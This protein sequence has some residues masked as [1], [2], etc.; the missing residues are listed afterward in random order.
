MSLLYASPLG[1]RTIQT[2]GHYFHP[3]TSLMYKLGLAA[4]SYELVSSIPSVLAYFGP[5]L[6]ASFAEIEK[7]E[8]KL[9]ALL[10][11]FLNMHSQVTIIGDKSADTKRRVSTISFVVEGWGSNAFVDKVYELT[12]GKMGIRWG[13]FY[14]ERLLGEFLGLNLP[15]G[16]VRV[17]F[18][19]YN[20]GMSSSLLFPRL[21]AGG[22]NR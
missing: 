6:S 8:G 4:S 9:Q 17:S 21:E 13:G 15:D 14:S 20:T 16:V 22:C 10:L 11:G 1:L 12:D 19:H 3:T 18:V 7:H 5:N 2:L